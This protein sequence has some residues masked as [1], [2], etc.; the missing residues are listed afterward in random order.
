MRCVRMAWAVWAF[1]YLTSF[2]L[3]SCWVCFYFRSF[4]CGVF[5][6]DAGFLFLLVITRAFGRF[7][8]GFQSLQSRFRVPIGHLTSMFLTGLLVYA[9]YTLR[10]VGAVYPFR[11]VYREVYLGP[12]GVFLRAVFFFLHRRLRYF[13]SVFSPS[14]CGLLF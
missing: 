3:F 5:C 2:H 11:Y 12:Y 8:C 6:L 10:V 1:H 7:Y 9:R 14:F 13:W 4:L